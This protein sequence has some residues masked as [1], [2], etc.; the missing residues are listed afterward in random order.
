MEWNV[1]KVEDIVLNKDSLLKQQENK[2]LLLKSQLEQQKISTR[3]IK[4]KIQNTPTVSNNNN[5]SAR[6]VLV[7]NINDNEFV[8]QSKLNFMENEIALLRSLL[9]NQNQN[10]K[11][12]FPSTS[13]WNGELNLNHS[14]I[15]VKKLKNFIKKN[16]LKNTFFSLFLIY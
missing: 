11:Q 3:E 7:E 1:R 15:T 2:I 5:V 6:R 10:S 14:G 13:E 4:E 8:M 12:Q 9:I 16:T